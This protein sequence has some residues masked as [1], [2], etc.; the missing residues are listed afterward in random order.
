[1]ALHIAQAS[2]ASSS[3]IFN[4]AG[5]SYALGPLDESLLREVWIPSPEMGLFRLLL[6]CGEVL[7]EQV[8][9]HPDFREGAAWGYLHGGECD[10]ETYTPLQIA[11]LVAHDFWKDLYSQTPYAWVAGFTSGRLS[12]FAELDRFTARIGIAHFCFLLSL[13]PDVTDTALFRAMN[14]AQELHCLALRSYRAQ[15]RT[16]KAQGASS[17]EAWRWALAGEWQADRLLKHP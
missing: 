2:L 12:A 11:N 8:V 9:G 6:P 14:H 4:H 13:V 3:G 10:E 1:M 5:G 7:S 17:T 15:V 16:F